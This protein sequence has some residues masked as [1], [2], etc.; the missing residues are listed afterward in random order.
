MKERPNQRS[1]NL[2]IVAVGGGEIGRPGTT[3]DTLEIDRRTVQMT[4]K[5]KP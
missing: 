5:T 1:G 2:K 3:V 4:G